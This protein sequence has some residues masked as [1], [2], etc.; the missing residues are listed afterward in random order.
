MDD[1][2]EAPLS[3]QEIPPTTKTKRQ[4]PHKWQDRLLPLMVGLLIGLTV[5]FFGVTFVQMSYLHTSMLQIPA[6]DLRSPPDNDWLAAAETFADKTTG[7]RLE[8][9]AKLEAYLIE[10]RYHQ[11]SALLMSGLWIRYLGFVTGMILALVG[12]SFVLG[13]LQ[14][15]ATEVF[16]KS[17]L[18][19][20]SVKSSSP[21]IILAVLGVVLM[22]ATI[23][24]RDEYSVK[25]ARI[26]LSSTD[27]PAINI[28]EPGVLPPLDTYGT[29][30][31]DPTL[32]SSTGN[33]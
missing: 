22:F 26:Y 21:G 8:I 2:P 30:T 33:P 23:M 31:P 16:G 19:D 14:E 9:L 17:S 4:K 1:D 7:R 24:D 12:A 29:P 11:A 32:P 3:D 18:I 20:F 6:I 13:K 15:P 28:S 10:R 5:F 25:D 27:T